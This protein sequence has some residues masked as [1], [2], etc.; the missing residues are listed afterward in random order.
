M[1][2]ITFAALWLLIICACSKEDQPFDPNEILYGEWEYHYYFESIWED[3][4]DT[5]YYYGNHMEAST[6]FPNGKLQRYNEIP[7]PPLNIDSFFYRINASRDTFF[8]KIFFQNGDYF[9]GY[10]PNTPYKAELI[11]SFSNDYFKV[12]SSWESYHEDIDR[13]SL[14]Y[15]V[16][17]YYRQ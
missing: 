4:L 1:R 12:S 5:N 7:P 9:E 3:N 10:N 2:N 11:D 8:T 17:E 6:F 15:R 13:T 16:E 14:N